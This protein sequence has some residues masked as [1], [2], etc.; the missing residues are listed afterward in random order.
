MNTIVHPYEDR[1]ERALPD[2]LVPAGNVAAQALHERLLEAC[3]Q[4][5][6]RAMRAAAQ[7]CGIAHQSVWAR[8]V[9]GL[10]GA[11]ALSAPDLPALLCSELPLCEIACAERERWSRREAVADIAAASDFAPRDPHRTLH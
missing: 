2:S 6:S 7:L 3:F 9:T 5:L 4:T 8:S 1:R 11:E 10:L